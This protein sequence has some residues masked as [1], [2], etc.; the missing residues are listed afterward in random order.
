VFEID[1]DSFATVLEY[2]DGTDLDALLKEC[3]RLNERDAKCILLQILTA[4]A[5]LSRGD[6]ES[7]RPAIIH[8]DLKPANILLDE[9]RTQVK[10]TDFGLSKIMQTAAASDNAGGTDQYN[11]GLM[12]LTSQGAGTYWYL[13]PECFLPENQAR[14]NHKVDVWSIGVI[15]YQMIFGQ[16]P[17]G[18]GQTQDAILADGTILNARTVHFPDDESNAIL[19]SADG[20]DFIRACLMYDQTVRPTVAELCEHPYVTNNAS[21]FEN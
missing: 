2:C 10:I 13:P 8:Y 1:A 15:Y 11:D 14:I 18:H 5:Y 6:E 16:R 19:L 17:F 7:G 20:R 21:S 12:E 4:M 3:G 9:T